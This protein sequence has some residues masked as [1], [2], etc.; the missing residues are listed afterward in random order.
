MNHD[1][2]EGVLDVVFLATGAEIVV[3]IHELLPWQI[4][5]EI[6]ENEVSQGHLHE[7]VHHIEDIGV[8]QNVNI[9]NIHQNDSTDGAHIKVEVTVVTDGNTGEVHQDH[10]K[11]RDGT[12]EAAG[13]MADAQEVVNDISRIKNTIIEERKTGL[14][15]EAPRVEINEEVLEG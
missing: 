3:Q 12:V 10:H 2:L 7:V 15:L 1:R 5:E 4:S 6:R 11:D 9:D 13:M 14:N 8:H